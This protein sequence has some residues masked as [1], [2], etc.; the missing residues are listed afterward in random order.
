MRADC[1]RL[2]RGTR[3][4]RW[5]NPRRERSG[6]RGAAHWES[7][8]SRSW[9]R[10]PQ[11]SEVVAGPA[12]VLHSRRNR[13]RTCKPRHIRIRGRHHRNRRQKRGSRCLCST[14]T[15]RSKGPGPRLCPN[16]CSGFAGPQ[17]L[18][19]MRRRDQDTALRSTASPLSM[20]GLG[21]NLQCLCRA[22]NR[23]TRIRDRRRRRVHRIAI[24]CDTGTRKRGNFRSCV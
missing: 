19:R 22:D 9:C 5:T 15:R 24:Q 23:S 10:H 11:A 13:S 20:A 4:T 16:Q 1:S 14:A 18:G 17:R 7:C 3:P 21:R 2:P 8:R 6:V 12:D